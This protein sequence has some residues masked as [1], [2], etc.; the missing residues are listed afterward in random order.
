MMLFQLS[1]HANLFRITK[2]NMQLKSISGSASLHIN[3]VQTRSIQRQSMVRDIIEAEGYPF[4]SIYIAFQ[5]IIVIKE[6]ISAF[7]Q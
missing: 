2:I 5:D 3:S 6:I 1:N 4:S 7:E